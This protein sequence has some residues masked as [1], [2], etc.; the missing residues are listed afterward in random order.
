MTST[1]K[2][3]EENTMSTESPQTVERLPGIAIVPRL[4]RPPEDAYRAKPWIP[5]E[6]R[7]IDPQLV[8]TLE[9]LASGAALWPLLIFGRAGCGKS[10][11]ALWATD[12]LWPCYF[13]AQEL[14]LEQARIQGAARIGREYENDPWPKV[15]RSPFAAL[16]EIGSSG[17][18]MREFEYTAV[19][20]FYEER[21]RHNRAGL[22]C[23]NHRP[24]QLREFFDERV[25]DRLTCGTGLNME[26]GSKRWKA[27]K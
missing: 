7:L 24:E 26:G 6:K 22:Y 10:S 14:A 3:T 25:Y 17:Q 4:E 1:A 11:F 8:A 18:S 5:R 16:D 9:A 15:S 21:L 2:K 13:S 12:Q 23:S 20:T 19:M 27:S